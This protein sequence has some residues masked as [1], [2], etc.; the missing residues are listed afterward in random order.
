MKKTFIF[1]L[2]FIFAFVQVVLLG[3]NGI[4]DLFGDASVYVVLPKDYENKYDI[5][6]GIVE[7]DSSLKNI[8]FSQIED[9]SKKGFLNDYE[10]KESEAGVFFKENENDFLLCCATIYPYDAK[11][12]NL[13][14]DIKAS[15]WDYDFY[16]Q[17]KDKLT[18]LEESISFPISVPREKSRDYGY[19]TIKKQT[20]AFGE[21][22]FV[23]RYTL[24]SNGI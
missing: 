3:C 8:K 13:G 20:K 22:Y 14:K 18:E 15:I 6:G 7:K 2:S 9:Y 16:L 17:I 4:S 19:K 10:F 23:F 12:R 21:I 11:I 1:W 24:Y 5:R